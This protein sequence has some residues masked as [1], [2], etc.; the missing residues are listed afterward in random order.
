MVL[1]FAVLGFALV[2]LAVPAP[3]APCGTLD[4]TCPFKSRVMRG[5]RGARGARGPSSI[6][7]EDPPAPATH[8]L[9]ASSVELVHDPPTGTTSPPHRLTAP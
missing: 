3:P 8:I 9:V 2:A 5:A 7:C 1:F 6:T 4:C